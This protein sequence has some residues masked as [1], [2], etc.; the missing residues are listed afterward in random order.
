MPTRRQFIQTTATASAAYALP[1]SA[2]SNQPDHSNSSADTPKSTTFIIVADTHYS[3]VDEDHPASHAMVNAI[4]RIADGKTNWP[5]V[6]EGKATHFSCAGSPIA[7]PKGIIHLGDMTDFGSKSEL[8]GGRGLFGFKTYLGFRQFWEHDGSG[9]PSKSGKKKIKVNYPVYCGLGNHD[10]DFN[11]ANRERMWKYVQQRHAGKTPPVPV[12]DFD[13]DSLS[14]ALHWGSLRILQLHRFPTDTAYGKK[15]A[16]P[17]LKR[18]LIAAKKAN[19]HVLLCQHYGFDSFSL[20]SRWWTD[21][22]RKQL[23]DTITPYPNIIGL[24]HGHS[25]AT[26]LY[27]KEKLRIFR[28]NNMGW[29]IDKGNKDGHGS[30]A[31][32]HATKTHLNLVHVSCTSADGSFTFRPQHC[33]SIKLP[34]YKAHHSHKK[35]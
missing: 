18:Q 7:T 26:A 33:A 23:L 16:L 35:K 25:H 34:A 21:D 5:S 8:D 6:I 11:Q 27:Q 28:C 3:S 13:T 1:L 22:D 12:R 9:G 30:F 15:P 14:Y 32:V 10:L 17:W 2:Q 4:N 24:C 29:E 19:Q 31:L 20:Q